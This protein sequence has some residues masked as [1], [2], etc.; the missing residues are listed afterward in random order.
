MKKTVFIIAIVVSGLLVHSQNLR[1]GF[2]KQEYLTMIGHFA[3]H[4]DSLRRSSG[5]PLDKSEKLVY[6]SKELG[7]DNRWFMWVN[8]DSVVTL[9]VR[10]TVPTRASWLENAYT[11]MVPAQGSLV[12]ENNFTFEYKL[13]ESQRAAIHTGWLI[14]TAYLSR[15][16]LPKI[17]S[18][19]SAGYHNFIISGHSQGG[20]LS[21]LLTSYFYYLKQSG[22]LPAGIRFKTY[23]SAAPK[24]G[25]LY[26][27]Y[28][29]EHITAG[30]WAFNVVNAAD[31]VPEVPATVQTINDINRTNPMSLA[32]KTIQKQGWAKRMFIRKIYNRLT[33]PSSE[34]VENNQ[35]YLG[36]MVAKQ[37]GKLLSGF[38]V[39]ASAGTFNYTRTGQFIVLTGDEQYYAHFPE[40]S[41]NIWIHHLISAY[42]YLAEKLPDEKGTQT[43][44]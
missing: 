32:E 9:S 6:S 10:G 12:L 24:P 26:Y 13:A 37:I 38:V 25:N 34:Q 30:G 27:A 31:W 19:V 36:E 5:I 16:M 4:T 20:A 8:S 7:L 40:K 14:G 21:Y 15:D 22:R 23:C 18:L 2:V 33:K 3:R 43:G 39:P 29:F 41:E 28:D 17:D 44:D 1:S 11:D 42:W 35:K